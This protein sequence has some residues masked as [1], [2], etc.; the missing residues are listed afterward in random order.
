MQSK[1]ALINFTFPTDKQVLR[2]FQSI[3]VFK[4]QDF[5]EEIKPLS[6]PISLATINLFKAVQ[7]NFL[8]TPAKSHYLFNMRDMSKVIQGLYQINKFY[9]DTKQI[10]YRTWVHECLRVFHDRLISFEDR[11]FFK[12]LVQDQVEQVYQSNMKECTNQNEDD[13][14]FIDFGDANVQDQDVYQEVPYDDRAHLKVICEEK[15]QSMNE[16]SRGQAIDIVLFNDAVQY[17]CKIHRII[18]LG[19]GHGMLVGDGG[20]GRH[21][22]TKLATYIAGYAY[23]Q[24]EIS[25]NYRLREFREDIKSW[26][27]QAGLKNKPGVFLFSDNDIVN[28]AFIEDI[29]NI[30]SVGEIPNLF[31]KEDLQGMRDKLK[32]ELIRERNLT[33]DARLP[34]DELFAYF[35]SKMQ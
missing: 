25:K 32:K 19:K 17:V 27:E 1:F 20:S 2:I 3:L 29:N 6:E 30:L 33:K 5:D 13:T 12:K 34:D 26:S 4:L 10:I 8:P 22:L 18:K 24:V 28:E 14:I 23:Y 21:S 15:L 35:F 16:K 7:D 11:A 31:S 9:Q